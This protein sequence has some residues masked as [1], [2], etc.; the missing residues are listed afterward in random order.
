MRRTAHESE[1]T[2][3]GEVL[4]R[5]SLEEG[6]SKGEPWDKGV[7]HR[8]SGPYRSLLLVLT[9]C[10]PSPAEARLSHVTQALAKGTLAV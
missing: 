6:I 10:S 4:N 8:N 5:A 1:S 7:A 2:R 3:T 9:P